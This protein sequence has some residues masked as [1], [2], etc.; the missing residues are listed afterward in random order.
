MNTIKE[1]IINLQKQSNITGS[2]LPNLN[3]QKSDF[4][5]QLTYISKITKSNQIKNIIK[6]INKVFPYNLLIEPKMDGML[7]SIIY[8]FGNLLCIISKGNRHSGRDLTKYFINSKI[9]PKKINIEFLLEIR[10]ELVISDSIFKQHYYKDFVDSRSLVSSKLHKKE[11]DEF[12]IRNLELYVHDIGIINKDKFKLQTDIYKTLSE[13][14]FKI[15]DHKVINKYDILSIINNYSNKTYKCDG[16]IFKVNN[17]ENQIEILKASKISKHIIA[18]KN[19]QE[20]I[21]SVKKIE[22]TIS[23]D[24]NIVPILLIET[25]YCDDKK[26]NRINIY[27]YSKLKNDRVTIG[28]KIKIKYNTIFIYNGV[29]EYSDKHKW[30]DITNC[31]SCNSN[32]QTIGRKLICINTNC[33]SKNSAMLFSY[34]KIKGI[35]SIGISCI[36]ELIKYRII[37]NPIDIFNS[38][39]DKIIK[40]TFKK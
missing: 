3:L 28:C 7:V 22:F 29:F 21:S 39:I 9:I 12:F 30:S 25:V 34:I 1:K 26:C 20:F 18:F 6:I 31:F 35:K 23:K 32:L 17:I 36:K 37:S 11:I 2:F 40:D 10:G 4:I 27:S 5:P 16:I 15:I 13:N 8:E 14:K 33:I 19:D 24:G 38:E